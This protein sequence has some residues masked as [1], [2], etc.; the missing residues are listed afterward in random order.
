MQPLFPPWQKS[1]NNKITL[2]QAF[3]FSISG[4]VVKKLY[5]SQL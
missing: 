3:V 2:I 4:L 5:I 1:S